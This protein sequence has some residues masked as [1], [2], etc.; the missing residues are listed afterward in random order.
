[1]RF[2]LKK[3]KRASEP[4]PYNI[5]IGMPYLR[6]GFGCPLTFHPVMEIGAYLFL[7]RI[8]H[9]F[10][11]LSSKMDPSLKRSYFS[12]LIKSIYH[13]MRPPILKRRK[14][15]RRTGATFLGNRISL[16]RFILYLILTVFKRE[17]HILLLKATYFGEPPTDKKAQSLI[18][19]ALS[20]FPHYDANG[21]RTRVTTVKGWCLNRLTMAP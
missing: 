9:S 1:M 7:L 6:Q 14:P 3:I 5:P 8:Y 11:E 16:I 4:L 17:Y 12:L 2:L 15:T 20:H 13:L 10:C 19:L 18:Y 21:N